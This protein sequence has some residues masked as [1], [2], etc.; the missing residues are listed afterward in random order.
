MR[1]SGILDLREVNRGLN[2]A[3]MR[4]IE[5]RGL[6]M[7]TQWETVDQYILEV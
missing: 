7:R 2:V 5:K 4:E 3:P 6:A 1:D